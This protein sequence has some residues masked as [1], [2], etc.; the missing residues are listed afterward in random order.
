MSEPLSKRARTH[1]STTTQEQSSDNQSDS[2][3]P[4]DDSDRDGSDPDDSDKDEDP[5]KDEGPGWGSPPTREEDRNDS[6][7]SAAP[8]PEKQSSAAVRI[9]KADEHPLEYLKQ[10]YTRRVNDPLSGKPVLQCVLC[11]S[12]YFVNMS[13]RR[14]AS[15]LCT[16]ARSQCIACNAM[17]AMSLHLGGCIIGSRSKEQILVP[18]R[19]S[20]PRLWC[21]QTTCSR[22]MR[23]LRPNFLLSW[24]RRARSARLSRSVGTITSWQ[25]AEFRSCPCEGI[26]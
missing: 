16:P 3:F 22:K 10:L 14:Y 17:L 15:Q 1:T 5:D 8:T 4:G 18:R 25:C 24:T 9:P 19:A 23:R 2:D 26:S 11:D 12:A 21:Q 7:D 6:D 20:A 13:A